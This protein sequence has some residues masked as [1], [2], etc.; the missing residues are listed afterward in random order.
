MSSSDDDSPGSRY[1]FL[2]LMRGSSSYCHALAFPVGATPN[3]AAVSRSCR[4]DLRTPLSITTVRPVGT[5]SSSTRTTP[6]AD[7]SPIT[8][9]PLS[10]RVTRSLATLFP[11]RSAAALRQWAMVSTM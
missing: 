10:T 7:F 8:A 5:P 4:Y 2:I 3:L 6:P 1:V 9:G 11:I